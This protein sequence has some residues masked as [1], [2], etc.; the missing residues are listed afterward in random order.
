MQ[1]RLPLLVFAVVCLVHLGCGGDDG[2]TTEGGLGSEDTST[3]EP[4]Q[5]DSG[6][7]D[8]GT[9]EPIDA[10]ADTS[11][12]TDVFEPDSGDTRASDTSSDAESTGD[13]S[14]TDTSME[15]T[16][17][18]G[19]TQTPEDGGELDDAGEDG[20]SMDTV[21]DAL[22]GDAVTDA[23][24][25]GDG[26]STAD[27]EATVGDVARRDVAD[28]EDT[29]DDT[30]DGVPSD[31]ASPDSSDDTS[32]GTP[33]TCGGA[34]GQNCGSGE[35]CDYPNNSCGANQATG[36]CQTQPR[37]CSPR[38]NP[39]CGCDGTTYDNACKAHAAGVDIAYRGRC[40]PSS[41]C[42][43]ETC[44]SDEYCN[45]PDDNCGS[46]QSGACQRRPSLCPSQSDPV[47]G[48]NGKTYQNNCIAHKRGVDIE[49]TGSC[50][51]R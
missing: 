31:V 18:G 16:V 22:D 14:R 42:G 50:Q 7:E 2:P 10:R 38:S 46:G 35:Y 1:R 48:C 27:G 28:A 4:D 25:V 15:D 51:S 12:P 19:E 9:N 47:C 33:A 24:D 49:H 11:E 5:P 40:N 43:G 37:R 21:D 8:T 30:A 36:Q 3:Q 20:M 41:Q 6:P 32:G 44:S 45:Y 13:T 26:M 23:M 34:S 39:V 17:D 29:S